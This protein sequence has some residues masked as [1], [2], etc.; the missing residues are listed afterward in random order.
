MTGATNLD[1]WDDTYDYS[2][3]RSPGPQGGTLA[4]YCTEPSR[5]KDPGLNKWWTIHLFKM[6]CM[7]VTYLQRGGGELQWN[8]SAKVWASKLLTSELP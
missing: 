7:V 3:D 5:L 4:E 6:L 1:E 2:F 8:E